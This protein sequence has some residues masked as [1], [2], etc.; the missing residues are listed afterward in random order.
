[1]SQPKHQRGDMQLSTSTVDQREK[2]HLAEVQNALDALHVPAASKPM[3][4]EELDLKAKAMELQKANDLERVDP[5]TAQLLAAQTAAEQAELAT[6]GV[7]QIS[8][9][10]S[11]KI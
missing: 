10:I 11:Q 5:A 2:M 9:T 4:A 6:K 3:S 8:S 7:S 1:M